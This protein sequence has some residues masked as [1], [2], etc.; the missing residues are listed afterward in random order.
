MCIFLIVP[1]TYTVIL[2]DSQNML[3]KIGKFMLRKKR[4]ALL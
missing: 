3:R 4:V 2:L 1:D